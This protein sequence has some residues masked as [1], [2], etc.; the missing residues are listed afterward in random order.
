MTSPRRYHLVLAIY[1]NSRGF[2][3]AIFEGET[4]PLD[5]GAVEVRGEDKR[6]RV[7]LRVGSLLS[8][9]VPD[10]VV[11]Q[12][13]GDRGTRRN[14][15]I[16]RLNEDV[17][18]HAESFC[19]PITTFSRAQVQRCFQ[20]LGAVTKDNLAAEIAK[21]IPAFERFLPPARKVWKSEDA[22]MGIFDAAALV[23]TYFHSKR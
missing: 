23:L 15:R 11:L 5:W 12:D 21:D 22:R 6:T 17:A 9:Y 7:L 3:Y 13:T 10:V 4:A 1:L 16:R 2:A 19:I 20:Y 18:E 14:H 8:R